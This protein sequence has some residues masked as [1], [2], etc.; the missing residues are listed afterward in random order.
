MNK[1]FPVTSYP[2]PLQK[3]WKRKAIRMEDDV[4]FW[5][6]DCHPLHPAF[7]GWR[8]ITLAYGVTFLV[9][10]YVSSSPFSH[11]GMVT[12]YN[13]KFLFAKSREKRKRGKW[14]IRAHGCVGKSFE[15]DYW[16][17]PQFPFKMRH[18]RNVRWLLIRFVRLITWKT[19]IA[20]LKYRSDIK[21]TEKYENCNIV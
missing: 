2:P 5:G 21:S 8:Y 4:T 11:Q 6:C 17:F 13:T 12:R 16:P 14:K 7:A 20:A 1:P 19:K 10:F 18:K 15:L 9:Q 3:K